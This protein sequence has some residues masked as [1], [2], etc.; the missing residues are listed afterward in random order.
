MKS[1]LLTSVLLILSFCCLTMHD[2]K[3][4]DVDSNYVFSGYTERAEAYAKMPVRKGAI[5][6]L[7]NSLTD[8]GRWADIAP[9]LPILNRG[10][11]G[12]ISFGVY[13]RLDEIIRHH[14]KSVFLMIG[15]N[16]LKRDIPTKYII[17][18]YKKIVEKIRRESPRTTIFLNS[19]L[20]INESKLA[21]SFKSVNN[22]DVAIL[23][24]ALADIARDNKNIEFVN[25]HG[26]LADKDGQLKEELTPDG[27]HLEVVAY[28]GIVDYLKSIKAL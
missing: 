22:E 11:S 21:E 23:N 17:N 1:R 5:V 19:I 2:T 16:D 7:G 8:A 12:D 15:V 4:Q 18:N 10:I 3:A 28:I 9:E 14:P 27:I 20:P 6:F 13:A 26:I 25:L 24:Q